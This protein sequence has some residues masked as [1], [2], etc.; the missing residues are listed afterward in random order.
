MS[1]PND[2][3]NTI[4]S[5][6]HLAERYINTIANY[7][8]YLIEQ[9]PNPT[10]NQQQKIDLETKRLES[11]VA[12][13]DN[14]QGQFAALLKLLQDNQDHIQ[15]HQTITRQA[16]AELQHIKAINKDVLYWKK[17]AEFYKDTRAIIFN[18]LQKYKHGKENNNPG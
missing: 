15:Q 5:I 6:L 9:Q 18:E 7:M 10:P 16:L 1:T 13:Y 14:L 17:Q 11:V 3:L 8:Q 12:I 2:T 4:D